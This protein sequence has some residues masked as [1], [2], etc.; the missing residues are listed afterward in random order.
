MDNFDGADMLMMKEQEDTNSNRNEWV[1][2]YAGIS[3]ERLA[4]GKNSGGV[5][6]RAV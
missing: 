2:C 4:M 5:N 6:F 1:I 3:R